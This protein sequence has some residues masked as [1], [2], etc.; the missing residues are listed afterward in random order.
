LP[1]AVARG[2]S[3]L[4]HKTMLPCTKKLYPLPIIEVKKEE[5]TGQ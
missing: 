1:F 4:S 3:P 5:D 2:L